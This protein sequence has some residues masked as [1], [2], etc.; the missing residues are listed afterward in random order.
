M[1]KRNKTFIHSFIQLKADM[2]GTE[3][4]KYGKKCTEGN[5]NGSSVRPSLATD[6]NGHM[7]NPTNKVMDYL[8]RD[9]DNN[10]VNRPDLTI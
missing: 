10:L 3:D 6:Q 2:L 1:L 5:G 4:S 9:S 7:I 8:V